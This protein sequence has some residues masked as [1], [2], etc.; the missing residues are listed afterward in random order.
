MK[1]TE[2]KQEVQYTCDSCGNK[3]NKPFVSF[4]MI[5]DLQMRILEMTPQSMN[6]HYTYGRKRLDFCSTDCAIKFLTSEMKMFIKEITASKSK[7]R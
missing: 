4:D 7:R 6:S 3:F 1:T 5:D 2:I